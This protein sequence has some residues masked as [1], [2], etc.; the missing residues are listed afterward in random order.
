M[1]TETSI[2][3]ALRQIIDPDLHQD[4][5]SLG[6]V[7]NIEIKGGE[8]SLDIA[9]TTPACPV[10]AEFQK[11]A[12]QLVSQLKGVSAV[13]V[14][15]TTL[16][17]KT[18]APQAQSSS[19]TLTHVK[20]VIA[21]SSCKGG[22]GKSTM[23]AHLAVELARRGF[24]VGLA[25]V[26]IHGPSIPSLFH[27]YNVSIY[28]NENRQFIPVEYHHLK[29]MSFG[30]LLGDAPAVLRG[31]MVAQYVQ[32]ILHNTAWGDL[33]YLFIDMPP[34]TGDVQL[35]IT[36]SVRL[37]GAVIVTTRQ[38]LSLVDV[39]RGILMFEKVDVPILGI[40]ENMAYFICDQCNKRHEIFGKGTSNTLYDRFGL[41]SL[42]EIPLVGQLTMGLDQPKVNP[43]ITQAVD[44][45]VRAV[46]KQSILQKHVPQIQFDAT[47]LTLS[48]PDGETLRLPNRDVR[49]SCRCALCV[50]EV[51]GEQLLQA[52][53]VKEDIAPTKITPLGNYAIGIVWNDGHSSGIY[54]YRNLKQ[55]A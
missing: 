30:F 31:P 25:D 53:N 8:V 48:W 11:T 19:S 38:T 45:V 49:L 20:S 1:I 2:K 17:T 39:A 50:H 4:I 35:T 47:H 3:N 41:E 23:A 29:I 26:D 15:M 42:A 46:G 21:V 37:S 28:A 13:H 5:V 7:R 36:Q 22:V 51:T 18:S 32:Q 34:G 55:L 10:K 44:N 27:L 16:P 6:F 40:I 33:D 14:N 52:K 54:P 9:L 43:Y 12:E 24:K